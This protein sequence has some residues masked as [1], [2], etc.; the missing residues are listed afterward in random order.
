MREKFDRSVRF[1]PE[2]EKFVVQ[3][4]HF[5]GEIEIEE[6]AFFVRSIDLEGGCLNLSDGSREAL[7]PATLHWSKIDAALLCRISRSGT[8]LLVVARFDA[9][10]HAELLLAIDEVEDGGLEL[11]LGGVVHRLRTLVE[12]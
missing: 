11:C 7:D 2:E 3:V 9:S 5:R 10:A 12:D 8:S 4:G 1:L 6:A